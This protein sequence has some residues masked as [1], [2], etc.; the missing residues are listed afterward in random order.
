VFSL[1]SKIAPGVIFVHEVSYSG[2]VIHE[3]FLFIPVVPDYQDVHEVSYSSVL[4]HEHFLFISVVPD[5]QDTIS[6]V[7]CQSHID[8][9]CP[10]HS[11]SPF[12]LYIDGML[13]RRENTG[14]HGAMRVR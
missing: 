10:A 6:R 2:V 11:S 9:Y 7:S 3:C 8:T 4:I 1:E 12:F 14:E 5:Y 13:G